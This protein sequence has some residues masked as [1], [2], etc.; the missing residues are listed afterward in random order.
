[1]ETKTNTN[2]NKEY[3]EVKQRGSG[4]YL[5]V[6]SEIPYKI[7]FLD[8]GSAD[9]EHEFEDRV[10]VRR[11]FRVKVS[12]GEYNTEEL[13]WSLTKGGPE[14]LYGMLVK[15]FSNA[16]QA[17]GVTVNVKARGEGRQRRYTIKEFE[18]LEWGK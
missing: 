17:T 8:E 10:T 9:Y 5:R 1:M 11:D 6:E 16:G 3:E 13:T 7:T 18:A 14:S 2:W 4:N 12:G 15:L